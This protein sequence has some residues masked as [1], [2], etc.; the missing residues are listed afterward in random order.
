[1]TTLKNILSTGI[2]ISSIILGNG[3]AR[4]DN[5]SCVPKNTRYLIDYVKKNGKK[6]AEG[7][8][9]LTFVHKNDYFRTNYF[10][11][12]DS[13][14]PNGK[15]DHEDRIQVTHS[16]INGKNSF[17]ENGKPYNSVTTCFDLESFE[18]VNLDGHGSRFSIFAY[19]PT[20]KC[21]IPI[22]SGSSET[23]RMNK[24]I[25]KMNKIIKEKKNKS[26]R[27]VYELDCD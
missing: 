9:E 8:Y 11:G 14:K 13:S 16:S 6:I 7:N 27:D 4:A 23:K 21:S 12:G 25:D 15:I 17:F 2:L 1:M 19:K 3:L 20:L 22:K 5:K 10:D 24:L 18:D 26:A